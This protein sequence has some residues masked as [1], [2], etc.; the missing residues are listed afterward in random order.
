MVQIKFFSTLN[1]IKFIDFFY[2]DNYKFNDKNKITG[3]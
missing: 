1:S 2:Y 3:F